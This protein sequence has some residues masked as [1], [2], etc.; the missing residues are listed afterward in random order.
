MTL[1]ARKIISFRIK[2]FFLLKQ[3]GNFCAMLAKY[4][5]SL[6][7]AMNSM[8]DGY[9]RESKSKNN[10]FFRLSSTSL[11]PRGIFPKYP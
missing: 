1:N 9:Q 5:R 11:H 7:N 6:F 3:L 8:Y 2:Y 10:S 4:V